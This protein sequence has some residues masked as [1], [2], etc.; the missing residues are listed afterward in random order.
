MANSTQPAKRLSRGVSSLAHPAK[1]LARPS[2]LRQVRSA[3][4]SEA[5]A[6][7]Q[8]VTCLSE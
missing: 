1:R 6:F 4:A 7:P 3:G 2:S 5:P 8:S